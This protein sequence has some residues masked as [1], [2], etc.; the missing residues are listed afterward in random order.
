M[1]VFAEHMHVFMPLAAKLL[2]DVVE[3]KGQQ[4]PAGNP[5]KPAADAIAEGNAA[6]RDQK[7]ED[8]GE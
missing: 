3:T 8:G 5:R 7:S 6:P 1:P 4:R 2:D